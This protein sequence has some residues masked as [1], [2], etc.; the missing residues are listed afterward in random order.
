[1]PFKDS[2]EKFAP[3]FYTMTN[4]DNFV[5]EGEGKAAHLIRTDTFKNKDSSLGRTVDSFE[6]YQLTRRDQTKYLPA[7]ILDF[8]FKGVY[9]NWKEDD[10]DR[11][12]FYI[13]PKNND[14]LEIVHTYYIGN[15]DCMFLFTNDTINPF[16]G[17]MN[18]LYDLLCLHKPWEDTDTIGIKMR[19]V[20][21]KWVATMQDT[22]IDTANDTTKH[23]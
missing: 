8:E 9:M 22:S 21:G 4:V 1:M 18:M 2:L 23:H 16:K 20:N 5:F 14:I 12:C 3:I 6:N 19:L 17:K 15:P 10:I 7:K 13:N 11:A